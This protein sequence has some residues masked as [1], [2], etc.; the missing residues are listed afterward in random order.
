MVI[1][2]TTHWPIQPHTQTKHLIL[3][4]YLAAW[5]P[6]M[7]RYNGK[8]IFIDGFAGPGRYSGGEEGSPI[9]ALRSLLEHQYF[10]RPQQG[11]EVVFLFIE[12]DEARAAALRQEVGEFGK[13]QAIPGWVKT[14]VVH[15]EFAPIMT[16]LLDK[17]ARDG[18]QL[19]PTF[20]F[21]APFGF[22]RVP[23]RV[24][25]RILANPRCEC[26]LTFMYEPINRF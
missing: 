5:L 7:A 17:L 20:A 25:A 2:A 10:R 3:R 15:G 19:A 26:L 4:R 11:R 1:P 8:L 18:H 9:I 6:I 13:V 21:I 24:I 16:D 14:G 23:M 22:A 12:Q